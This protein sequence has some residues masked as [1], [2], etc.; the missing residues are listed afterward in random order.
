MC[1]SWDRVEHGDLRDYQVFN[2]AEP[3]ASGHEEMEG[4]TNGMITSTL[5]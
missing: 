1:S 5:S 4:I 2:M 3:G